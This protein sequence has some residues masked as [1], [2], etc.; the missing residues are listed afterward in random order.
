MRL[1]MVRHGE[2]IEN[3]RKMSMGH[4]HGTLTRKG[5]SQHQK[6]ARH[7]R[8]ERIDAIYSSDL[9]RTVQLAK[10]IQE[11]HAVPIHYRK[12]LRER[13]MG[14]FEGKPWGTAQAYAES[15]GLDR[16]T[17]TPAA[18]ESLASL[19]QRTARFIAALVKKYQ[20]TDKTILLAT[21]GGFIRNALIHVLHLGLPEG[22]AQKYRQLNASITILDVNKR[23][24]PAIRLANSVRHL[25]A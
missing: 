8:R 9:G 6:L 3:R 12:A 21:H 5:I 10:E 18:G 7:L 1:I 23:G 4:R 14:I 16:F 11:Y 20:H 2:T 15:H 24:K 13:N 19:H 25:S 22:Y 17:F